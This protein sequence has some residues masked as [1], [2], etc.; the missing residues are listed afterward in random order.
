MLNVRLRS[1]NLTT[2]GLRIYGV[3]ALFSTLTKTFLI[4][5]LTQTLSE[6]SLHA[7]VAA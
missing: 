2:C 3:G 7:I 5:F 4:G 1:L 6:S